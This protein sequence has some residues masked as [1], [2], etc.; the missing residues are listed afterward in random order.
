MT[1]INDNKVLKDKIIKL[2][3]FIE[4]RVKQN[5]ETKKYYNIR[6]IHHGFQDLWKLLEIDVPRDDVYGTIDTRYYHQYLDALNKDENFFP[7][8][9]EEHLLLSN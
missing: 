1:N 5:E 9:F 2:C 7:K 8:G 6:L 4:A 3:S